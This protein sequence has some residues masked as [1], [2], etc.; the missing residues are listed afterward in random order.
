MWWQM[1]GL[2]CSFVVDTHPVVRVCAIVNKLLRCVKKDNCYTCLPFLVYFFFYSSVAYCDIAK[3][4][5]CC[6]S[7]S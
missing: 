3:Q 6:F 1:P 7:F 2:G 5:V 4:V